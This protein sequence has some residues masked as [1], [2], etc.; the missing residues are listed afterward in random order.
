MGW[1]YFQLENYT[2]ALSYNQRALKIR[3]KLLGEDHPLTAYSY[4]SVGYTQHELGDNKSALKSERRE[5]DI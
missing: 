5:F 2:S 1:A 3:R 4:R